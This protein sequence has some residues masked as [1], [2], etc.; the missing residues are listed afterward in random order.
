MPRPVSAVCAC[1]V[2]LASPVLARARPGQE[3]SCSLVASAD[4]SLEDRWSH[5]GSDQFRVQRTETAFRG[6][7][8]TVYVFF[9]GYGTGEQGEVDLTYDLRVTRPNGKPYSK[10]AG[11]TGW[12]R[13][14]AE[15]DNVLLAEGLC[16]AFFDPKD[17]FGSYTVEAEARDGIAGTS[18]RATTEIQLAEYVEGPGFDDVD[19]LDSWLHGYADAP[20]PARV[21]PGLWLACEKGTATA[22][23][24]DG[25]FLELLELNPGC[26]ESSSTA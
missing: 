24:A 4:P 13:P 1:L 8:F 23:Q 19:A 14:V 3:F 15:P 12:N 22:F 11:L 26:S 16:R 21:V 2:A 7:L 20:E 18:V 5:A 10:H 17:P 6:Q 9:E 25:S